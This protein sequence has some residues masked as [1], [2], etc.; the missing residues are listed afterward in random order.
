MYFLVNKFIKSKSCTS[1]WV[2]NESYATI[3]CYLSFS[4]RN[5]GEPSVPPLKTFKQIQCVPL[6]ISPCDTLILDTSSHLWQTA[7]LSIKNCI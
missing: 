4:L 7:K 5:R 1:V 6:S 3:S 2:K